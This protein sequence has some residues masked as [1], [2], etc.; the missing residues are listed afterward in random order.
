MESNHE[1]VLVDQNE[2]RLQVSGEPGFLSQKQFEFQPEEIYDS[3]SEDEASVNEF[4]EKEE[5]DI[6]I[7]E[8]YVKTEEISTLQPNTE[9][10]KKNELCIGMEFSSNETAYDAYKKF[11]GEHGF[12]VR[13]QRRKKKN[14]EVVRLLYV[15]SKE[16]FRK[17]PKI[18]VIH[19]QLHDQSAAMSGKQPKTILTDESAAMSNAIV[20]VFPEIKHR[21][22]VWNIY[23]NA[24][25]KLSHVFHGPGHSIIDFGKCVY[26]HEEEVGWLLAWSNMLEK[27]NL[28]ENKWLQNVFDAMV[29]GRHTFTADMVSTQRSESMNNILKRYLKSS[30]DLL[31]F[32]EHYERVFDDRRYNEL[33]AD[34]KIMH[35]SSVLSTTVEMLQHAE[36]VYT[37]EIFCLFQKQYTVTGDYVAKK[38]S[39]SEMVNEYKVSYRGG[40][41]EYLVNYD[42]I[43]QAIQCSSMK[44]SFAGI[45]C[46]HALKV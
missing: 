12:N 46:R 28:R 31:S 44:Y 33:I 23:Q 11:G 15:C 8:G 34:F 14:N 40:P 38:V 35:T 29:Y 39:K 21:L 7:K 42:A 4:K 19:N 6:A 3:I 17:E 30:Y 16:G 1:I 5:D 37:P 10:K 13:K 18:H 43:N 26:D 22:C 25:K 24:A 20:K 36:E 9:N 32:F 45:L 27:H 41:Q 2:S